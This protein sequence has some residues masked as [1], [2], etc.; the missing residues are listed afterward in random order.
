M[1]EQP[2]WYDYALAG[3]ASLLAAAFIVM[4]GLALHDFAFGADVGQIPPN[5][6]DSV[7]SWFKAVKSPNGVPC[8]D[9]DGGV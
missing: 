5:T 7:R 9:I 8:C 6:P 1:D 3:I 4:F 2:R